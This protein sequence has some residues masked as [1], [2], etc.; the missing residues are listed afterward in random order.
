MKSL[1][2]YPTEQFKGYI[3]LNQNENIIFHKREKNHIKTG[4]KICSI[5]TSK[6]NKFISS[7]ITG[8]IE[9]ISRI[10]INSYI[11]VLKLCLHEIEFN[12]MCTDCGIDIK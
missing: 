2:N 6:E 3:K 8:I 7:P 4:E 11:I 9:K 1:I 5:E 10:D 12:G